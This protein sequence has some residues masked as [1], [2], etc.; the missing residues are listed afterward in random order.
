MPSQYSIN[1]V[2]KCKTAIATDIIFKE[3]S[4]FLRRLNTM[5]IAL[6]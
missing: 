3:I 5:N 2:D 6:K 4:Q 1:A